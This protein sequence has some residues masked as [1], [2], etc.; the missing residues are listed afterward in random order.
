MTL[1]LLQQPGGA[2]G[3]GWKGERFDEARDTFNMSEELC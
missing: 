2:M 1:L 3:G